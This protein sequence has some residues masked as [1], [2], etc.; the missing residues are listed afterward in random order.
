MGEVHVP[1]ASEADLPHHLLGDGEIPGE[2]GAG[3]A[4]ETPVTP[5][6]PQ[7]GMPPSGTPPSA[8]PQ[9]GTPGAQAAQDPGA[10]AEEDFQLAYALDLL[11]GISLLGSRTTTN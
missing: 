8:A 5:R 2:D 9:T 6:A 1:A 11:R 3:D 10:V 4:D 7:S